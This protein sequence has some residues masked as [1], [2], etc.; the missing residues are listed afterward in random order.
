MLSDCQMVIR[1]TGL[2]LVSYFAYST[3]L[4]LQ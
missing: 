4:M 2:G 3:S 1:P